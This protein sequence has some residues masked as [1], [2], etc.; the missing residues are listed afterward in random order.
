MM[1]V[2][3][4]H[5]KKEKNLNDYNLVAYGRWL[6]EDFGYWEEGWGLAYGIHAKLEDNVPK[7]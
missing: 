3:S 7:I 4:T 2:N 1:Q 6:Y 5:N